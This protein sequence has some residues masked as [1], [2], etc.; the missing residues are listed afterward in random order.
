MVKC[1]VA[2][3]GTGG[4]IFPA[5]AVA[6]LLQ[7][8]GVEVN[9]VGSRGRLE[10]RIIPQHFPI[11]Y[12]SIKALRGKGKLSLLAAPWR[13]AQSIAQ[14]VK[15]IKHHKPKFV[16]AMGGYV[17]GPLG[18]AAW[19]MRV[20]LVVHEQNAAAG[21]TNRWLAKIASK[22]FQ[23]FPDSFPGDNQ[24]ITAVGNPV[25]DRF[26]QIADPQKRLPLNRSQLRVLIIGGSQGARFINQ[27]VPTVLSEVAK[28]IDVEV[29]HQTGEHDLADVESD[30][31][32]KHLPARVDAFIDDTSVAFEWA[33]VLFCRAGALTVSEVAAAGVAAVFVPLPIAVDDHQRKNA[34]VLVKAG[35]AKIMQQGGWDEGQ[36][37]TWFVDWQRDRKQLIKMAQAARAVAKPNA[38]GDVAQACIELIEGNNIAVKE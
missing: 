6:R 36:L 1:F 24:A 4:H 9:W 23:A 2:A 27:H 8:R 18:V 13:I 31:Q 11:H 22:V 7:N 15:L 20:P 38:T 17:C 28:S 26:W 14:A 34:E 33:D 19:L 10:E 12:L 16:L 37:V 32:A 30:Y 25:R 29:W 21:L 35:A 5:L 3:G